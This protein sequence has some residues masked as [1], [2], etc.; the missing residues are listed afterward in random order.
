MSRTA[1][2]I[3]DDGQVGL[4]VFVVGVEQVFSVG[5]REMARSTQVRRIREFQEWSARVTSTTFW[6]WERN[7]LSRGSCRAIG[8]CHTFAVDQ[9]RVRSQHTSKSCHGRWLFS[10]ASY[11]AA[12][13]SPA[14][15]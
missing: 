3:L 1:E 9:V 10:V 11:T 5:G 4:L 14:H 7:S 12:L 2:S 13:A 8:Y 6:D 15:H